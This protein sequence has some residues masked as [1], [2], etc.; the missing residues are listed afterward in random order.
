MRNVV[1][2]SAHCRCVIHHLE[3]LLQAGDGEDA[4]HRV[5]AAHDHDSAARLASALVGGDETAEPGRIEERQ[6]GE[7]EHHDGRLG[8]LDPPELVLHL[9]DRGQVKL[10]LEGDV[11]ES[12][13]VLG[14]YVEDL[15]VR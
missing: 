7:V 14:L 3:P 6:T 11:H 9:G 4:L 15:H 12:I 10:A 8:L 1:G 13:S 2:W 5:R